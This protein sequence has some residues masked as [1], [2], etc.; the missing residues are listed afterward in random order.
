[1]G[2]KLRFSAVL[3]LRSYLFT[4]KT[5]MAVCLVQ[6]MDAAAMDKAETVLTSGSLKH[7]SGNL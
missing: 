4:H 7:S 1:M 3:I 5:W 6:G 2:L